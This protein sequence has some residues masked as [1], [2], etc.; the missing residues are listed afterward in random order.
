MFGILPLVNTGFFIIP[1]A[2][3]FPVQ[4]V[5]IGNFLLAHSLTGFASERKVE[6]TAIEST[7]W[8]ADYS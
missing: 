6:T 2:V 3:Y 8:T 4:L 5:S 1:N 7:D